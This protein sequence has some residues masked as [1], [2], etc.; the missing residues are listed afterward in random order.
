MIRQDWSEYLEA[1]E[2]ADKQV[3]Q[4]IEALQR[5]VAAD[6]TIVIFMGD[7]GPCFQRGKMNLH[8]F[9]LRVPLA[10]CGPGVVAN[11]VT[12]ALASEVDL[13]PTIL[14]LLHLSTPP[15]HGMSLRKVLQEPDSHAGHQWIF[16][17][18]SDDGPLPNDGMQE[19]SVFDGRFQ[20]IYREN[21]EKRR[22][23]NADLRDWKLWRNCAYAETVKQKDRFPLQYELLKQM[24][25]QTLGGSVPP[26][27]LYD[28]TSDPDELHNLAGDVPLQSMRR[29]RV[30][31]IPNLWSGSTK[32]YGSGVARPGIPPC[33]TTLDSAPW[34]FLPWRYGWLR[35][36]FHRSESG[37]ALL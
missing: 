21:L 13:M 26:F 24:D 1:I 22:Q 32:R 37:A 14:D 7:H 3:G 35:R 16:A 29:C 11:K 27:E 36:H 25:P 8:D 20:L 4:A 33:G 5:S 17:E 34:C 18:I 30:T 10:I 9:G 12:D 28:L 15:V 6:Q 2:R 31:R 23:V 19:R